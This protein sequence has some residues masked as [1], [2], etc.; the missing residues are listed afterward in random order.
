MSQ[1]GWQGKCGQEAAGGSDLTNGM[2]MEVLYS[3]IVEVS[4]SLCNCHMCAV[5]CLMYSAVDICLSGT[6]KVRVAL[7]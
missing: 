3:C 2:E 1:V 4:L 6:T 5:C 7:G